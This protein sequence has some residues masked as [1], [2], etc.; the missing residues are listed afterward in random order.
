MIKYF[1]LL[2]SILASSFGHILLAASVRVHRFEVLKEIRIPPGN[3]KGAITFLGGFFF[4]LLGFALWVVCL[5]HFRIGYAYAMGSVSF[6]FVALLGHLFFGD[7]ILL[8]GWLGIGF[9]ML[10]VI[11]LNLR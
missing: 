4:V 5:R 7:A 3:V 11:L 9:I 6:F 1:I 10:G 8:K 2:S